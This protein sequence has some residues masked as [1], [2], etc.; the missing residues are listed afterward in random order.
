MDTV[1]G[2]EVMPQIFYSSHQVSSSE[3]LNI[4]NSDSPVC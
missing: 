3:V 1:S 4:E 2:T